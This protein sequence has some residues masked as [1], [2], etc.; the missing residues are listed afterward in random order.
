MLEKMS[1]KIMLKE[2]E[3]IPKM[4]DAGILYV[5]ERFNVA[6]HLCP[7]GCGTKIVTPLGP[8]EW[9]LKKEKGEPSL[10]PSIGNW[11]IPCRSHYLITDGKVK[12]SDL[13]TD[14]QIEN[15]RKND[16]AKLEFYYREK[17]K[18]RKM[19]LWKKFKNWILRK[20]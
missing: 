5:S 10:R 11:Q 3:F 9:S 7:C 18:P 4:L 15:G 14:E 13:W 17:S 6:A 8:C 20:Q 2:V 12:W 19:T 1:C 16:K